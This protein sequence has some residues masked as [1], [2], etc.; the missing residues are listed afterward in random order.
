MPFNAITGGGAG[1]GPTT[2][3]DY[4]ACLTSARSVASDGDL[5]EALDTGRLFTFYKPAAGAPGILLPPEIFEEAS[6][7]YSNAGGDLCFFTGADSDLSDLEAR[8]WADDSS[9]TATITGGGSSG[10]IWTAGSGTSSN[11]SRLVFTGG[12]DQPDRYYLVL[13]SSTTA[14]TS[15]DSLMPLSYHGDGDGTS[16]DYCRF[17]ANHG[18]LCSFNTSRTTEISGKGSLPQATDAWYCWAWRASDSDSL[19]VAQ[20][21]GVSE[22][23]GLAVEVSDSASDSANST[24]IRNNNGKVLTVKEYHVLT[25]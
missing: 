3:A 1:A 17:S 15:G 2:G 12:S 25:L 14:T 22:G 20:D 18:S 10:F 19:A 4:D 11:V 7:Y 8:G 23:V 5:Y 24:S 6:G 13:F 9:G 21:L 16:R